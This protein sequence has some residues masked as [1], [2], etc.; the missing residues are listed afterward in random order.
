[1]NA[2]VQ[3]SA[4]KEKQPQILRSA[5]DDKSRFGSAWRERSLFAAVP[6]RHLDKKK[7][8]AISRAFLRL[9]LSQSDRANHAA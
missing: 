9:R 2:G 4:V 5:Q 6:A 8:P 3:A 7:G 1:V